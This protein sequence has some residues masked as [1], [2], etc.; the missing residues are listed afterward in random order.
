MKNK[1]LYAVLL[2]Y[3]L[4]PTIIYADRIKLV[5]PDSVA[6]QAEFTCK[7]IG[8]TE[9]MVSGISAHVSISDALKLNAVLI[10]DKWQGDGEKGDISIFID[11][12][13]KG[14]FDIGT[15]KLKN[16]SKEST[17]ILIESI[18]FYDDKVK[19]QKIDSISLTI[20]V[21]DKTENDQV[22]TGSNELV[23]LKITNY[24][25]NFYKQSK[26]YTLTI[27]NEDKLDITPILEDETATYEIIGNEKLKNGSKIKINITSQDGKEDVYIINIKKNIIDKRAKV[28]LIVVIGILVLIN[29]ARLLLKKVNSGKKK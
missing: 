2:V 19:P 27:D 9:T 16:I 17:S 29:I 13:V 26:E 6:P 12:E 21:D 11:P 7:I 15:L 24:D 10:A 3:L 5:C 25:I 4:L 14:S 8:E 1:I 23:D 22:T 18:I 20:P 28:L